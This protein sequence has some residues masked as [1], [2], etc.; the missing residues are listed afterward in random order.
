MSL[1]RVVVLAVVVEGRSPSEVARAYSVSRSWIY[2]LVGRYRREGEAAFLARSRRPRT[3]PRS[4]CPELVAEIVSLRE[5]LTRAGHDAGAATIAWHLEQR[6]DVRVAAVTVWRTLTR[7]GLI[8]PQP[9]KRPKSSYC[10][11]EAELPNEM[12][13]TDFTHTRY[14]DDL[15]A[16]VLTFLDDHSRR[17]LSITAHSPVTGP[18]VV[19]VFRRTVA[20]HGIPA[21]LL[22]DNGTVFTARFVGGRTA[23]EHEL[24][25]L[26][27]AKKNSRP[28]HPQ[29]CGK[30]ER[31]Q[32]TMKRW[33]ARQPHPDDLDALQAQL[34]TWRGE[35]N[36]RRPHRSLARRTPTAAYLAR[37]KS[38]PAERTTDA[39]RIRHD[40]VDRHGKI[41]L[42]HDGRLHHIGI[43]RDH[44]G[45]PALLLINDLHIRVVAALTGELI[46]E[47]IL[48]PTR[49]YQ[50]TGRPQHRPRKPS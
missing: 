33:L 46:R 30:V 42:R 28:A 31:F 37:P 27:V 24:S 48:D 38:G 19:E 10:R 44:A 40:H 47:L 49:D 26:G 17:A 20:A 45:T 2:T 4:I 12:W 22:S 8:V 7:M 6:H 23:L 41:T 16:E 39:G 21:T 29:T 15:D 36:D 5:E 9:R 34:D 50:P 3:S 25:R 14:G 13:Q 1:A 18:V 32:Q 35:Y 11:F 43:G